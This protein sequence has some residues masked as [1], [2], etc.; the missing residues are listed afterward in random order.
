MTG[1]RV[2]VTT[3]ALLKKMTNTIFKE[4][5]PN[6]TRNNVLVI[7]K[8]CFLHTDQTYVNLSNNRIVELSRLNTAMGSCTSLVTVV[9]TVG[10]TLKLFVCSSAE[11]KTLTDHL[12]VSN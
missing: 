11:L 9:V 7:I 8:T 12:F 10:V 1:E 5:S 4:F 2:D 3:K 6:L